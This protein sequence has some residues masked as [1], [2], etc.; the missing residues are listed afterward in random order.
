MGYSMVFRPIKSTLPN[1][2]ELSLPSSVLNF[3]NK[4]SGLILIT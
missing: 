4:K 1:F 3:T 2:E